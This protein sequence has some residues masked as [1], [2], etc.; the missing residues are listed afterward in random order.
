MSDE[1]SEI[2]AKGMLV[3]TNNHR[4]MHIYVNMLCQIGQ[5]SFQ[6]DL[7]LEQSHIYIYVYIY[8]YINILTYI[9]IYV[10]VYIYVY[11]YIYIF[12]YVHTYTLMF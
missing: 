6:K 8:T 11:I 3:Y 4:C 5:F 7:V 10:H 1:N 9:Y 12:I 2:Q